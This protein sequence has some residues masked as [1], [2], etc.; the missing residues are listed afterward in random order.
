MAGK[1]WFQ[2]GLAWFGAV[3]WR[4]RCVR[5]DRASGHV[6]VERV[7]AGLTTLKRTG[8]RCRCVL[9]MANSV[10]P[11]IRLVIANH[12]DSPCAA[13][14]HC[15]AAECA[16]DREKLEG[17]RRC[18]LLVA[19]VLA[20]LATTRRTGGSCRCVSAVG[21]SVAPVAHSAVAHHKDSQC[22]AVMH[23]SGAECA[24]DGE[25]QRY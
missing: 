23:R 6:V 4:R 5:R 25:A 16:R 24:R 7:V 8:G 20:G 15:S 22:A 14:M 18:C 11:V 9:A 13:V 12:K 17:T 3:V 21:N 10:A 2:G 19:G 1:A